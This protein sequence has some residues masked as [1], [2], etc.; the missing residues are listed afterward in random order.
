MTPTV[1]PAECESPALLYARRARERAQQFTSKRT[2]TCGVIDAWLA[3]CE[4]EVVT[5]I[6]KA[7]SDAEVPCI[8]EI[9]RGSHPVGAKAIRAKTI[10]HSK[11]DFPWEHIEA[12]LKKW[13]RDTDLAV[14]LNCPY[15]KEK[16]TDAHYLH[17]CRE[18]TVVAARK[19]SSGCSL[20]RHPPVNRRSPQQMH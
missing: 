4:D 14:R 12:S 5:T 16:D 15:Y 6:A 9:M 7:L 10:A 20:R 19:N 18:P 2:C 11:T 1:P 13:R 17:F 8:S 3:S